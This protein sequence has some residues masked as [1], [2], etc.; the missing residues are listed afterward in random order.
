M[1]QYIFNLF[2]KNGG[3][4]LDGDE[5]NVALRGIQVFLGRPEISV[6][7]KILNHR[8]TEIIILFNKELL[9]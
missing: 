6:I 8:G 3:A 9:F 2:V 4:L 7:I 5:L 1:L